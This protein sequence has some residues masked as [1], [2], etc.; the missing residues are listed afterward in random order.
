MEFPVLYGIPSKGDKVKLWKLSVEEYKNQWKI[1]RKYGYI[2]CKETV[3]EKV[4]D[5]GK[6]IG[7][8]NE[9]SV[10]AQ[11]VLEA[12][13]L[14][15][16]QKEK[17]YS[18]DEK[19]SN[20]K[21][22][23]TNLPMLA[24]DYNKR[25][26]DI[27]F[28]CYVQPKIDGVRLL[29]TKKNGKI[30]MYSRTGKSI[31]MQ[32]IEKQYKNIEE[33]TWLDG[34]LFSFDLTFEEITGLFRKQ[35]NINQTKVE[36]L[37]FYIF[38]WFNDE[39]I[40]FSERKNKYVNVTTEVCKTENEVQKFHDKYIQEGYE[41]LMLRN[42]ESMYKTQYRS[43][44]LQK[45]KEFYDDEYEIIGAHEG[46][47][48]DKNTIIFECITKD[49]EKFSVRPRG[50]YE[51]RKEMWMHKEDYNG[52]MLTVRYQNLTDGNVPRFPVGLSLRDYE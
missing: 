35:K 17:G 9:T 16:K 34:E 6:N 29:L 49:G 2:N 4:I 31:N 8:K 26:H 14:F 11:A 33:N 48:D 30:E 51:K 50:T 20:G 27:N 25:K 37:K 44:D 43:K 40:P 24:H 45:Y 5:F 52:K 13:A 41:G 38:D 12:N 7:K 1:V 19:I 28:P 23:N 22:H 3:S 21:M 10:Y 32:H 18:E 15:K 39:S 46:K 36:K 47:G 42:A